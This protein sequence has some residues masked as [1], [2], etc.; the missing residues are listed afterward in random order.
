MS[1]LAV[2][3]VHELKGLV[4]DFSRGNWQRLDTSGGAVPAVWHEAE[5]A[6]DA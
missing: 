2:R 5:R 6:R 4:L 3:H 1:E